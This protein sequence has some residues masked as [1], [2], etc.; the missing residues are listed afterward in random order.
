MNLLRL[1][2]VLGLVASSTTFAL[3]G[4]GDPCIDDGFGSG[5][6]AAV[7]QGGATSGAGSDDGMGT[8]G[9]GVS[10]DDD[11]SGG[12]SQGGGSSPG[13]GDGTGA[14]DT[15]GSDTDGDETQG[16]ETE[17]DETEGDGTS[18]LEPFCLDSDGDGF[19]DL[20]SCVDADP[21]DPPPGH[22]PPT[23][24]GDC[25][26]DD[27]N[28]FPGAAE[29][30]DPNACTNDDDDDGFGD[31]N[32]GMGVD[33]GTDCD[34]EDPGA[35]R[36]DTTWCIDIDGDGFGDPTNCEP[37]TMGNPPS[38][39]HVPNDD[40]CDDGNIDV[41]PGA[42]INEPTLC[43][44]DADGDGWGPTMP[45][46]GANA[47]S[48]CDDGSDFTFPGAA[49]LETPPLDTAC[50]RDEDGDEYGDT[51]P[52]AGVEIG[53]DCSDTNPEVFTG[54]ATSEPELCTIDDDGDGWG[55]WNA[56]N[57]APGAEEGSD[58]DDSSPG[59]ERC[60]LLVTQNGTANSSLD[61][62][63]VP[64]LQSLGLTVI[65]SQDNLSTAADADPTAIVVVSESATS[66]QVGDTFR[67][68]DEPVLVMEA[69]IWDDMFMSQAGI[70]VDDID[71]TIV[72]ET[73]PIAAGQTGTVEFMLEDPGSGI[74][75]VSPPA[76]AQVVASR[77][78]APDEVTIYA[79]EAGDTMDNGF[80][81]PGRRIGFGGDVDGGFGA[82]G[83]LGTIGLQMFEA[84][85]L[86]GL[87]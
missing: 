29:N 59:T 9:G 32:P 62:P 85:V 38:P 58:C 84:A 18:G 83:Q 19:A 87:D 45:P 52:P 70:A 66:F 26:D 86:W 10:L 79:F 72:D 47:G 25:D 44:I 37:G 55:D 82:N 56:P 6:C 60:A 71:I 53:T 77:V 16:D 35:G 57:V 68:V 7:S 8:D 54:A 73:H 81:A 1:H 15:D 17:G 41:F 40:D 46:P 48:D 3:V 63:M 51:T 2:S 50:L 64:L 80:T 22:I 24:Q 74:F 4:C 13:S 20:D 43:T 33:P 61:A 30:E 36:C 23:D 11:G 78:G 39:D 49:P 69:L 31:P 21:T 42:A 65:L 12:A 27:A 67:D 28:T 5:N 14:D 75:H 34:D 76:G